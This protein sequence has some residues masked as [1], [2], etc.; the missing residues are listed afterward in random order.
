M[1]CD[2]SNSVSESGHA[3]VKTMQKLCGPTARCDGLGAV[4]QSQGNN[5]F[6]HGSQALVTGM[7]VKEGNEVV[8]ER[9]EFHKLLP[10]LQASLVQRG[11][12]MATK[13]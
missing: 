6:G 10:E 1:N 13:W 9:G 2:A 4:G 7:K 11:K 8:H 5:D 12:E 3:L